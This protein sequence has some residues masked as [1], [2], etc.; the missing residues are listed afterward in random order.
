MRYLLPVYI[1]LLP[2]NA[3]LITYLQC[4]IWVDMSILR[5]WKEI[6]LV[7]LLLITTIKV[8]VSHKFNIQKIYKDNYILGLSTIFIISTFIYI[9]FPYLEIKVN[10]ILGFKYDRFFIFALLIGFFLWTIRENF[11]NILKSVFISAWLIMIVFLPWYVFGDISTMS[12]I[13]GYSRE[14]STYSANGCITFSQN[15]SGWHN[16]F[17]GT[18]SDPIRFSVFLVVFYFIYVWYILNKEIKNRNTKYAL[19]IVPTLLMLIS[20]FYAYTKT[21]MLGLAFGIVV[22]GLVA[23]NFRYKIYFPRRF[24]VY[25]WVLLWILLA[26]WLYIKRHLFL[27]PEAISGRLE[28]LSK[29][30]EMFFYNPMW[31]G[32]WIAWP[33]SQLATSEDT[34]LSQWVLLFL[35]ENWYVQILLEQGIL[36]VSFFIALIVVL[37]VYLYRIVKAKKDYLSIGI[38]TWF[39]SI[40]FMANFTHIFEER[41]TSY[42][43]F[44]IVGAYIAMNYDVV[45]KKRGRRR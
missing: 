19:L 18:F 43:L 23:N 36:W 45:K 28:N 3:L 12:R 25:S 20:V 27:H 44:M 21:S 29:S 33:R 41:A 31:F 8:L 16:R 30:F 38:F 32:L 2:L 35:P 13:F 1:F 42:I 11:N 26:F 6:I 15:V 40:L 17:Q 10:A 39:V 4:G 7:L 37:V 5:F 14:V 22:F 9:F 24:Y 34:S